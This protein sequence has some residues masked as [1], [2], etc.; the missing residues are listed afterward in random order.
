MIFRV[1]VCANFLWQGTGIKR[2]A[3]YPDQE[4][5]NRDQH[6]QRWYQSKQARNKMVT[7][8][9]LFHCSSVS[10]AGLPGPLLRGSARRI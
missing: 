7:E 6:Q 5:R 9:G 10:L 4:E 8:P 2:T 3:S 1:E